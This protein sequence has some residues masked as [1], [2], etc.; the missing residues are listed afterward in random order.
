MEQGHAFLAKARSFG[1]KA[2]EE[3]RELAKTAADGARIAADGARIAAEGAGKLAKAKS[4]D[5]ARA[6]D[7][8]LQ[9][10]E[11][12]HIRGQPIVL[13]RMIA[14]GGY[15]FVHMARG[16]DGTPYAVKRML[17]QTGEAR[18]MAKAEIALM[19]QLKHPNIVALLASDQRPM[20]D[21]RGT[22]Y[23]LAMELVSGGTLARHVVPDATGVMPPQLR[24]EQLL[25]NFLDVLK[26]VAHLHMQSPPLVHRDLKLEN[27]LETARGR[28]KLCDFGSASTKLFDPAAASRRESAHAGASNMGPRTCM[29]ARRWA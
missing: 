15:G 23:L 6:L 11:T 14:E 13:H 12:V 19:T 1:L 25:T 28:C 26:A 7:E 10:K 17:C 2:A 24:E 9:A 16:E 4:E 8:R 21:G 3:A 18:E 29:W 5:L 20:S 27:V 22:E